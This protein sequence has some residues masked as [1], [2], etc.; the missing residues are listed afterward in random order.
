MKQLIKESGDPQSVE[1]LTGKIACLTE[2]R[3]VADEDLLQNHLAMRSTFTLWKRQGVWKESRYDYLDLSETECDLSRADFRSASLFDDMM[4]PT[5]SSLESHTTSTVTLNAIRAPAKSGSSDRSS[6][7]SGQ[8]SKQNPNTYAAD[9]KPKASTSGRFKGK[10][11]QNKGEKF[12]ND[13]KF[14]QAKSQQS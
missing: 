2:G 5:V 9:S 12:N 6:Y 14:S 4:K 1:A 13:N 7:K 3:N 11:Y 8:A 10:S